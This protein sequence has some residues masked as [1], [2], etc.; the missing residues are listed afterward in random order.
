M[1]R[2]LARLERGAPA[3][4]PESLDAFGISGSELH[5]IQRQFLSHPTIAERIAALQRG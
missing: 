2:A 5:G 4:L 3:H 1:L